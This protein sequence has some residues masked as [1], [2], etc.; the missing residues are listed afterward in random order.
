MSKTAIIVSGS[1]RHLVNASSS[2]TIPGDYFLIVD[3]DIYTT[4]SHDVVGNSFDILTDNL[5][6]SHVK[7]KS[8]FV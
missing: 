4:A 1:L 6:N 3:K 8:V 2:W 7:F 5:N